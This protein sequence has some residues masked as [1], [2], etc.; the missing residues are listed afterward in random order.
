MATEGQFLRPNLFGPIVGQRLQFS[1]GLLQNG[2]SLGVL[3]G[4]EGPSSGTLGL[5]AFL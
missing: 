1:R 4:K 3:L 5:I 2:L